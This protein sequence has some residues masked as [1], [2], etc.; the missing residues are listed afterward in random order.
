MEE[1]GLAFCST[2]L[3]KGLTTKTK[4]GL[5]I[6]AWQQN[7]KMERGAAFRPAPRARSTGG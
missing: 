6:K 2:D 3:Q 1:S 4:Q 7:L 5:A